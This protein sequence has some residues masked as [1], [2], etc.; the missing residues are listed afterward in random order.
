M[1]GHCI[2]TDIIYKA[3]ICKETENQGQ[4]KVYIGMASGIWKKRYAIHK[5]S[6]NHEA[7][8]RETEL[9]KYV[10]ALKDKNIT[11]NIFFEK[12]VSGPTYSKETKKCSLC[13]LEKLNIM[14]FMKDHSTRILN[15]QEELF[16]K[17]IHRRKLCLVWF[18]LFNL[19][20]FSN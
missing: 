19:R 9:S 11:F 5:G 3:E 10:W 20:P 18:P 15:K 1:G 7:L 4:G 12:I 8:R 2:W 6:F 16:N 14:K 13:T 17:C